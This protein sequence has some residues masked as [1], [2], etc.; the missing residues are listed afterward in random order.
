MDIGLGYVIALKHSSRKGLVDFVLF[1]FVTS[2]H[3][4]PIV[5]HMA[6]VQDSFVLEGSTC[7]IRNTNFE[8]PSQFHQ[9]LMLKL[10]LRLST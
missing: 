1:V 2:L 10:V 3:R 6:L 5:S 7:M 4:Y 8:K 9:K